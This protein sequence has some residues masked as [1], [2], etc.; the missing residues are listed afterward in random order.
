MPGR[1][2]REPYSVDY[3]RKA[4]K[5]SLSYLGEQ[6]VLIGTYHV[7]PDEGKQPRCRC[8]DDVYEGSSQ[9]GCP[10]CY[11]TT[12]ASLKHVG[13]VWAMFTDTTASEDVDKRGIWN[14]DK[15]QVQTEWT[16]QLMEGDYIA[17]CDW[18]SDHRTV[19]AV[20]GIYAIGEV[21][22]GSLRQGQEVGQTPTDLYGQKGVVQLQD[23]SMPIF[24]YTL[25]GQAFSRFDGRR[26]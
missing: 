25:V 19:T 20:R 16:P 9:F 7:I 23:D 15:R 5:D 4:V 10:D 21:Q 1:R 26:Y 22:S 2:L 6:C 14:P 24:G 12:F 17:R 11:G 18:A 13:R 8:Y 3:M